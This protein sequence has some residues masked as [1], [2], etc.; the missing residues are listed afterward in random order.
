ML[1]LVVEMNKLIIYWLNP[2]TFKYGVPKTLFPSTIVTEMVLDY[3]IH[4][5]LM[6]GEYVQTNDKNLPHNSL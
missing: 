2:F 4:C 3:T 1:L 5:R 6:F